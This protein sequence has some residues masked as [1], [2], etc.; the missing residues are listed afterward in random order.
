MVDVIHNP[1][2]KIWRREKMPL[3]DA[4][5]QRNIRNKSEVRDETHKPPKN[6]EILYEQSREDDGWA[7]SY[8][9]NQKGIGA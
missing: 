2:L 3:D 8:G 6:D 4:R 1:V 5:Y 9:R 7:I